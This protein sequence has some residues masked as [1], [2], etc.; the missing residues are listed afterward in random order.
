M[1]S[2]GVLR[3]GSPFNPSPLDRTLQLNQ[4]EMGNGSVGVEVCERPILNLQYG[5]FEHRVVV[6]S[7]ETQLLVVLVSP[8][9][10]RIQKGQAVRDT[11]LLV[12]P[13][14]PWQPP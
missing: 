6:E 2:V 8:P 4:L 12:P 9:I 1:I 13:Q 7:D 14:R 11:S 10:D 3:L 5:L